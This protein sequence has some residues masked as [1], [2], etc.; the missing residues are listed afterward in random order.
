MKPAET[1]CA[2]GD[3]AGQD[4]VPQDA[5]DVIASGLAITG[6]TR[7][8]QRRTRL[9]IAA[10]GAIVIWSALSSVPALIWF[11]AMLATQMIDI[12]VWR[13]YRDPDKARPP[14]RV[15]YAA[16]CASAALAC[17]AY[18]GFA[19]L[20]WTSPHIGA[21]LFAIM[22]M[23]GA[24]LHVT[25][26]MH[27]ERRT[28]YAAITAHGIVFFAIPACSFFGFG[29]VNPWEATIVLIGVAIYIGHLLLAFREFSSL[30]RDMRAAQRQAL[31]EKAIAER[32]SESKS[33]FLANMS[34]EIRT[35]MNGVLGMAESLAG[36]DLTDDQQQKLKIIRESG[37]LL[38]TLLDDLL[39]L[40]KIEANKMTLESAPFRLLDI[41]ER[42]RGLYSAR[43]EAKGLA[44]S[45]DCR[46]DCGAWRTGDAHRI[47]QIANNL[48]SNAIKFTSSGRVEAVF[49]APPRGRDG[50]IRIVVSDT[51][52]GVPP[53]KT[54]S[55]FEPF[56]QADASTTREYGGT[57]LGLAIV[58]NLANAMDGDA[59]LE[60]ST[61]EGSTF[62][63]TLCAPL[64][65]EEDAHNG[66]PTKAHAIDQ[67]LRVLA[68]EDNAVNRAVVR[69]FLERAGHNVIFAED[70]RDALARFDQ[71]GPFDVVLM[72]ISMPVLDGLQATKAL[73]D[74]GVITP[75]IAL[76]A[77][78]MASQKTEFLSDG[79]D[80]YLSKP[81]RQEVLDAELA[82]VVGAF[83]KKAND[84]A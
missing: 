51:G 74:R 69:A 48:I 65:N 1:S 19:L 17:I 2:V 20:L 40:S 38:M 49:I 68:A 84:A 22:W 30:S 24:M 76:T 3:G 37:A 64:H 55:L 28:Y 21:K 6:R 79:F 83:L 16:L 15:Q 39:D 14:S 63:A 71:E 33:T 23:C 75:V 61:S 31:K 13:D 47:G 32:A 34:H 72:D 81:L 43:A 62:V 10:L 26:H 57:G 27:H 50:E 44:F 70:G 82:R 77:H 52:V 78:A 5:D 54:A 60:K 35:P 73:R 8:N 25:L 12:W 66:R 36:T 80:G 67:P 9:V 59:F 58:R 41:A 46:G 11:A 7:F 45:V 53:E 18:G 56:T 4:S 29:G 42:V